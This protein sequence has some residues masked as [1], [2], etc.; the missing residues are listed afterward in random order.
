[1]TYHSKAARSK[2]TKPKAKAKKKPTTAQKKKAGKKAAIGAAGQAGA[3][4]MKTPERAPVKSAGMGKQSSGY[5]GSGVRKTLGVTKGLAKR[6]R[7]GMAT[8]RRQGTK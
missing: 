5:K 7:S 3:N 4:M 6:R 1:M 8:R 2:A